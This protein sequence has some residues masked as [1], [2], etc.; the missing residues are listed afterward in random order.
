MPAQFFA[1]D[2]RHLETQQRRRGK[3]GMIQPRSNERSLRLAKRDRRE[4]GRIDNLNGYHDLRESSPPIRWRSRG[5][6]VE[7]AQKPP[8]V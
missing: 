6:A 5:L 1:T 8:S 4:R 2:I 3:R 7:L